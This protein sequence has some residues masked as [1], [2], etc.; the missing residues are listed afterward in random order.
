VPLVRRALAVAGICAAVV[1]AA[2]CGGDDDS[3]S[4]SPA[5][6]WAG[7]F[8]TALGTWGNELQRATQTLVLSPSTETVQEAGDDIRTA[9]DE[10][11]TELDALG[12]PDTESGQEV[13]DAVDE[14]TTTLD[15][16]VSEVEET[17]E[18]LG[19][20]EETGVSTTVPAIS[21]AFA[22]MRLASA[23]ALQTIQTAAADSELTDAFEQASSCDNLTG[24]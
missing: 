3:E 1:L 19:D 8:C 11:V 5:T 20:S 10:L 24:S 16:Q 15:D 13:V 21:Q 2:S 18:S 23:S 6:E 14:L 7:S 22:E 17:I 4:A 12:A 9:T